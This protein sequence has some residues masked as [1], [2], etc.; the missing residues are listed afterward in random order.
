MDENTSNRK[1][2]DG[3]F[4]ELFSSKEKILELYN[5]L[6][7]TSYD[8]PDI[9]TIQTL[10]DAIYNVVKNDL[11]FMIEDKFVILIEHQST[12][13]VNIT[14][15]L[16]LYVARIYEKLMMNDT[17]YREKPIRVPN[18]YMYVLYNG[19]KPL[20]QEQ[21]LKLS[22]LYVSK[23]E[24]VYLDLKVKVIN[25]NYDVKSDLLNKS[26]TVKEYSYFIHL[27]KLNLSMG[28][29]RDKAIKDAVEYCIN[30]GILDEF[31]TKHGSE[32]NNMLLNEFR[33]EDLLRVRSE[34]AY[35]DGKIDGEQIGKREGI[36][37]LAARLKEMGVDPKLIDEAAQLDV[38]D[39]D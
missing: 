31:L 21:I 30:K 36:I 24:D 12:V 17:I 20:P 1:Y 14:I 25:I 35:E 6:E 3:I 2:K 8:D 23:D 33:L 22:D 10:E 15:R 28:M 26:Q 32:V 34:E 11:A 39:D 4:R 13:S 16:L 18:P 19:D 37:E 5:A 38:V 29:T 9:I 7:G 27:V